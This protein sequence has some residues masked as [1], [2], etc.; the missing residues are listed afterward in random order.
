[1]TLV[2][3]AT[4]EIT[5]VGPEVVRGDEVQVVDAGLDEPQ[6]R[7]VELGRSDLAACSAA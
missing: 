7:S 1:M 2:P 4:A 6:C 5:N 3:E